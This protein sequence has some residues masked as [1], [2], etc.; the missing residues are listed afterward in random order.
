[1]TA[2]KKKPDHCVNCGRGGVVY[3]PAEN[4]DYEPKC[5]KCAATDLYAKEQKAASANTTKITLKIR[6]KK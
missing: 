1:M 6:K 5:P 3:V 2:I 4:G